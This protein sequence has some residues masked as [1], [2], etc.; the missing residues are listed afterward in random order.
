MKDF[1]LCGWLLSYDLSE[2]LAKLVISLKQNIIFQKFLEILLNNNT[3]SSHTH[4]RWQS[5]DHWEVIWVYIFRLEFIFSDFL[6][7]VIPHQNVFKNAMK[8]STRLGFRWLTES[9][10][11]IK[12]VVHLSSQNFVI[13]NFKIC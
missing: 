7:K 4:I 10:E 13:C 5:K 2:I 1:H 3:T 9:I 8:N 11:T 6:L 12:G